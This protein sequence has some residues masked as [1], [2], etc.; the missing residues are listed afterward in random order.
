LN[1]KNVLIHMD[2]CAEKHI[3]SLMLHGK[4][5][6]IQT[7]LSD[8]APLLSMTK[9]E[10]REKVNLDSSEGVDFEPILEEL[11]RAGNVRRCVKVAGESGIIYTFDAIIETENRR[12]A[13]YI[14]TG[15]PSLKEIIKF[16]TAVYDAGFNDW[17]Y[18]SFPVND[19]DFSSYST[20]IIEA[21]NLKE[22]VQK[23]KV[24]L[25]EKR[26]GYQLQYYH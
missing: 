8:I 21:K 1:T 2:P 6:N 4:I 18:V 20:N 9:D 13:V 11:S 7:D 22:A 23:L 14:R 10:L 17:I 15:K 16:L 5:R 24:L 26:K 19:Y 3:K 12:I 25:E